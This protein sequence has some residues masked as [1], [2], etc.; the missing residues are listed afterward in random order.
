MMKLI[1]ANPLVDTNNLADVA[2]LFAVK[3]SFKYF[4]ENEIAFTSVA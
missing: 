1:C 2:S 3:I 4:A